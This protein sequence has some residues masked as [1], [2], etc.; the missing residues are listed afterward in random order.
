[1]SVRS[2]R[3]LCALAS[4]LLSVAG[5]FLVHKVDGNGQR[6]TETRTVAP[7][8]G[9]ESASSLDVRVERGDVAQ[10][11]V[12]IDSNLAA[13]VETRVVGATLRIDTSEPV[14]RVVDGPQVVVTM[15]TVAA[16]GLSG[17]GALDVTGFDQAD[18]VELGLDGSGLLTFS[19]NVPAARVRS[20]GSGEALLMGAAQQLTVDMD[21][22]GA[23]DARA[24]P[25]ATA[26]LSLSGSGDL[27][28]TVTSAARVSISGSGSV[29][30]FGPVMVERST[31][32]GDGALRT[33]R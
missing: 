7:F 30:L 5:C 15:P 23:V 21:G 25:A 24:F 10:V 20:D 17:S 31:I 11:V 4:S 3:A 27:A 2:V 1:M 16:A 9:V 8:S 18:A 33:H 19:G 26:D 6:S 12:S 22:S 32:T 29:D 14:G 28:A 13:L